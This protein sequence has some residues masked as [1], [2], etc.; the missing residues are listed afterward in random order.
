MIARAT[1]AILVCCLSATWHTYPRQKWLGVETSI[2]EPSKLE[3]TQGIFLPTYTLFATKKVDLLSMNTSST[4][5]VDGLLAI[6]DAS[7]YS[8]TTDPT[9][10]GGGD[11]KKDADMKPTR[12]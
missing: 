1:D 8:T 2:N 6:C 7:E 3:A 9:E 4:I 5:Q 12:T 10:S 11:T